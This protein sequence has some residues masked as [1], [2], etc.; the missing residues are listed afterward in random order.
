MNDIDIGKII[1]DS[2][3]YR[4]DVKIFYFI[5]HFYY[6]IYLIKYKIMNYYQFRLEA[7]YQFTFGGHMLLLM[8]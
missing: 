3:I 1:R 7:Y 5:F 6:I 8:Y 2:K 4:R